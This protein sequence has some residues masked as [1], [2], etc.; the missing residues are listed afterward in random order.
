M[1]SAGRGGEGG[2]EGL[3][4][5]RAS[6][7]TARGAELGGCFLA[8]SPGTGGELTAGSRASSPSAGKNGD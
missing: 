5:G 6:L 2:L 1:G 3:L 8:A 7:T 4:L